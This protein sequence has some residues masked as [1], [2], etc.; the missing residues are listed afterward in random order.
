MG[1]SAVSTAHGH[2]R[3]LTAKG[4]LRREDD[5][6]RSAE[7]VASQIAPSVVLRLLGSVFAGLPT[8]SYQLEET[9]GVRAD[10]VGRGL[11][12]ALKVMGESM[13]D[14]NITPGDILVVRHV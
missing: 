5:V 8:E 7:L 9:V 10:M 3:S 6:E 4:Y 2:M 14:E 12:Y 13:C 1:L 11:H